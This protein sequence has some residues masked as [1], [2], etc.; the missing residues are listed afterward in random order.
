M[1]RNLHTIAVLKRGIHK[2]Y[3]DF[4]RVSSPRHRFHKNIFAFLP[5]IILN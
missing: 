1:G 3:L 2:E 4:K 5:V